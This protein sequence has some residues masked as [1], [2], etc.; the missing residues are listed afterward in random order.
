MRKHV[1]LVPRETEPVC[2]C[3]VFVYAHINTYTEIY[4]RELIHQLWR[5]TSP[6]SHSL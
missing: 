6:E 4:F 2:V 3:C 5:L 1:V